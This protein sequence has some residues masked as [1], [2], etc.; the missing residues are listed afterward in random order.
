MP[1]LYEEIVA[2]KIPIA[3]HYSDLY[4]PVTEQSTAIL[5]KYPDN[6]KNTKYFV[7]QVEG[8]TWYDVPFA[9]L[10]YWEEKLSEGARRTNLV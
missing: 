3:S 7:N 4:F 2:A 9:F 8:G 6:K 10:P 5:A 1:S